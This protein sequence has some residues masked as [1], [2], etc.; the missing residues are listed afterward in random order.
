ME[1]LIVSF[2]L[3]IY[4]ISLVKVII[5]NVLNKE[6]IKLLTKKVS[7]LRDIV[8][9]RDEFNKLVNVKENLIS[10][11]EF[12][13]WDVINKLIKTNEITKEKILEIM[14]N[15]NLDFK[16]EDVK[17]INFSTFVSITTELYNLLSLVDL[18]TIEENYSCHLKNVNSPKK[19]NKKK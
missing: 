2:F 12:L 8:D 18:N 19:R 1:N 6:K 10:I 5:D 14:I 9:A 16:K 4:I 17:Q 3:I 7:I 13:I 15:Y 11:E